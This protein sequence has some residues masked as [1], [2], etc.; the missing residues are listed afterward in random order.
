MSRYRRYLPVVLIALVIMA[1]AYAFAAANTVPPTNAGDG[2]EVISGYTVGTVHYNLLAADPTLIDTVTFTL[3]PIGAGTATA[4]TVKIQ[5][6]TGG[7]WFTCS[8]TGGT[9]YSCAV[10]GGV[11]ALAAN[12]LRVVAAQ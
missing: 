3:T 4:Q 1:V 9:N 8:N 7:A 2:A 11:T 5:L 6:V 12:N 10:T